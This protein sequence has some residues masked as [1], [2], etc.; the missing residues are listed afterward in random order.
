LPASAFIRP[1]ELLQ[2]LSTATSPLPN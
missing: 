2:Y 1:G